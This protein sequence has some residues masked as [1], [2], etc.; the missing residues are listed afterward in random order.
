MNSRG[1]W[2]VGLAIVVAGFFLSPATGQEGKGKDKSKGQ[3]YGQDE[4]AG[5]GHGPGEG[6]G[7]HAGHG[8]DQGM[9]PEQAAQMA[10]WMKSMTPGEHHQHLQA[11]AGKWKADTKFRM[12]P[13]QPWQETESDSTGKMVMGGRYLLQN[14][15]GEGMMGMSFEGMG[16][17]GYDNMKQKYTAVWIDNMG[18]MTWVAEGTCDGSGKVITLHNTF[19]DPMTGKETEATTVYRIESP[20]RYIMEMYG[21]TPDGKKFKSMEIV[22]TRVDAG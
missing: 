17:L 16:I 10:M 11:M 8:H 2:T 19:L 21:M 6:H 12:G 18:T 3:G 5:H 13:E 14:F 4:H 20:D 7:E 22:H 15:N 9:S 1:I